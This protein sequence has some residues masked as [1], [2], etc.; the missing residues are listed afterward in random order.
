MK[1]Y[2]AQLDADRAAK[3]SKGTNHADLRTA[4]EDSKSKVRMLLGQVAGM[5]ACCAAQV[6]ACKD[7]LQACCASLSVPR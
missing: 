7:L 2:R 1:E 4:V 5:H 3:L 6:F